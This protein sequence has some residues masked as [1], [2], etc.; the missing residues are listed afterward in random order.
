METSAIVHVITGLVGIIHVVQYLYNN[1]VSPI[2][3]I[4]LLGQLRPLM[5]YNVHVS[6]RKEIH[7]Q[8]KKSD[9]KNLSWQNLQLL[10]EIVVIK[11]IGCH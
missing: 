2:C 7:E 10:R 5:L 3:R 11:C 1:K 8:A 4:C 6:A 9:G